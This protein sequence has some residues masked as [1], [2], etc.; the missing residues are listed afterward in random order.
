MLKTINISTYLGYFV[1]VLTFCFGIVIV[2]GFAFLNVPAKLR[3]MFG[4]VLILWGLYRFVA[5][6]SAVKQ[7]KERDSLEQ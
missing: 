1:S 5:T 3:I 2:S 4:I 6:R 7:M